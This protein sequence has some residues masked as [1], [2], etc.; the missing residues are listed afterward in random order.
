MIG[1]PGLWIRSLG[2]IEGCSS[3]VHGVVGM[4]WWEDFH[5]EESKGFLPVLHLSSDWRGR[6]KVAPYM[7]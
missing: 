4:K 6:P 3:L 5:E 2:G 7:H 1:C